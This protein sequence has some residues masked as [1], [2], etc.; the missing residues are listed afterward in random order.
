MFVIRRY[1]PGNPK[2]PWALEEGLSL[3]PGKNTLI[4]LFTYRKGAHEVLTHLMELDR[5][6][7]VFSGLHLIKDMV[8]PTAKGE[9]L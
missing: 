5:L 3:E 7:R 6:K 8:A 2:S 9:R 4:A 1:K